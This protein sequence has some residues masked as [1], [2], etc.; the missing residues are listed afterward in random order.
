MSE[1]QRTT[2]AIS[3][4][5]QQAPVVFKDIQN[6]RLVKMIMTREEAEARRAAAVS[7]GDNNRDDEY[8]SFRDAVALPQALPVGEVYRPAQTTENTDYDQTQDVPVLAERRK[9]VSAKKVMAKIAVAT[10]LIS[11]YP[12]GD[13]IGTF[14]R[15][16]DAQTPGTMI[17]DIMQLPSQSVELYQGI[18]ATV[19]G[20][21]SITDTINSI[22]GNK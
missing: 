10:M 8:A 16:G 14:T 15:S 5:D 21:K 12:I 7:Q 18:L 2:P 1:F 22:K 20:A 3:S 6:G 13:T 17:E 9:G 4:A 19:Q 11:A